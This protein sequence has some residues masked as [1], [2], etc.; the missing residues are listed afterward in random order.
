MNSRPPVDSGLSGLSICQI[1]RS[2][3]PFKKRHC[4]PSISYAAMLSWS[5]LRTTRNFAESV[6]SAFEDA[7]ERLMKDVRKNVDFRKYTY[8]KMKRDAIADANKSAPEIPVGRIF[9]IDALEITVAIK[10]AADTM[11]MGD[12]I[13]V[14]SDGVKVF[15]KVTFPMLTIAKCRLDRNYLKYKKF[16]KKIQIFSYPDFETW[17]IILKLER[18]I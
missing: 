7:F 16:P 6:N 11:H 5:I 4:G 9:A 12:W 18:K 14:K 2:V 13:F 3:K 15:M 17:Q 8:E 1:S 10:N